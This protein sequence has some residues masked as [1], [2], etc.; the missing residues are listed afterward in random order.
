MQCSRGVFITCINPGSSHIAGVQDRRVHPVS[1]M[2]VPL[3]PVLCWCSVLVAVQLSFAAYC[4][5]VVNINEPLSCR[6]LSR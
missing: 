2:P 3:S 5:L 6:Q 4:K 1:A